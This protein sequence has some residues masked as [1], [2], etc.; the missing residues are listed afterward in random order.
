MA[1]QAEIGQAI[2]RHAERGSNPRCSMMKKVG[3]D[4]RRRKSD[5]LNIEQRRPRTRTS[6]KKTRTPPTRRRREVVS[7]KLQTLEVHLRLDPSGK[8]MP[9]ETLKK[10]GDQHSTRRG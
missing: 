5:D 4:W 2:A 3:N 10:S 1:T 9:P 8:E 7:R 6:R